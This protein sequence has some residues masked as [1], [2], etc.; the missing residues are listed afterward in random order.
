MKTSD[1]L[2]LTFLLVFLAI[3]GAVNLALY[4]EYKHGD[5]LTARDLHEEAFVKYR[6]PAPKYLSL[7][8]TLW[9]NIIPSDSFYVEFQKKEMNLEEGFFVKKKQAVVKTQS[10]RLQGDTLL[11]DGNNDVTIHRPFS[12]FRYR[13]DLSEINIYCRG[14]RE[15]R[16]NNGQVLL[17]G[18]RAG[19]GAGEG[20]LSATTRLVAENSTLWIGEYKDPPEPGTPA[21]RFDSL[22]IES[23]NSIVLLNSHSVI[24][25]LHMRLDDSSELNDQHASVGIPEIDYS[26]NSRV[27]L[28]GV[29]LKKAQLSI[30]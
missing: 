27:N 15:I 20:G 28:T 17:R 29:N 2:L 13:M 18:G 10:Y 25:S 1:K 23:R 5:I 7:S 11:I 16:V 14:L 26:H 30:H 19:E 6:M 9:V 24:R 22:D 8:G 3:F 4:A 12:D 21:E